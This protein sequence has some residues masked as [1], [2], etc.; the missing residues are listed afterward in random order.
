MYKHCTLVANL[1]LTEVWINNS[2]TALHVYWD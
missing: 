2:E 1:F